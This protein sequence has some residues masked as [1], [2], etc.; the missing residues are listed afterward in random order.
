[1]KY[2]GK[3]QITCLEHKHS[4]VCARVSNIWNMCMINLCISSPFGMHSTYITAGAQFPQVLNDF[5][6]P[7]TLDMSRRYYSHLYTCLRR[8]RRPETLKRSELRNRAWKIFCMFGR[9]MYLTCIKIS[10]KKN[11]EGEV[12]KQWIS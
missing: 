9:D 6:T 11:L 5:L 12:R 1:M 2:C 3:L 7:A 8:M 4:P 10:R